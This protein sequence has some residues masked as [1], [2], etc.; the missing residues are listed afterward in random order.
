[1]AK[2]YPHQ[3]AISFLVTGVSIVGL[4]RESIAEFTQEGVGVEAGVV[5][6]VPDELEG[7]AADDAPFLQ[8]EAVLAVADVRADDPAEDVGFPAARGA[9]AMAAERF[10]LHVALL[11]VVPGDGELVSDHL[12]A[13]GGKG[14]VSNGHKMWDYTY[15]LGK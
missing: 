12:D 1:M 8:G 13:G 7:V 10:E 11:A 9:G 3:A 15:S 14:R 2:S 6:V 5:P 4:G